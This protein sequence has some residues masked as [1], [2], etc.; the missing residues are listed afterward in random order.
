MIEWMESEKPDQG[1]GAA[2]GREL[3]LKLGAPSELE[4]AIGMLLGLGVSA[5]AISES[6]ARGNIEDAIFDPVLDPLA[7]GG[8]CR[9]SRSRRKAASRRPKRS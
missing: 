7:R 8:P 1:S 6:Y 9:P 4:E 3:S 5:Q 2:E